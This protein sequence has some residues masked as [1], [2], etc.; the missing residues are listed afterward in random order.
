MLDSAITDQL[1]SL[2]A[3]LE[4]SLTLRLRPSEHPR[5]QELRD[6]LA[7]VAGTSSAITV[8]EEGEP[9]PT[10]RFDILRGDEETGITFRAI[11]GG[12]ELSSLVLALLNA[13][14]KGKLPDEGLRARIARL[15]GPIRLRTYVSLSC[16][17]CPDVVQYLDQLALLHDDFQH[18]IV[19]GALVEE[20]VAQLGIQAVP[21]VFDVAGA[22][23]PR[24]LRVGKADLPTLLAALEEQYGTS[25]ETAAPVTVKDYD[26]AVIGGGPAGAAAAIYS[27][28]KGLSTVVIA[29]QLGGQVRDTAGIE[30]LI[31]VSYT[32]GI[33][34]AADLRAHI[35]HNEIDLLE[36]RRVEEVAGGAEKT[37]R[38]QGGEVVRTRFLIVATGA[39]WRELGVPGEREYLG[40][41]VAFCPHCDGPFYKGRP[42]AVVGGGNSGIEAAIDLAGICSHVTVLEFAEQLNADEVLIKRLEQLP[43]V[44]VVTGARATEILGDGAKVTG[45]AW[46]DRKTE[47]QKQRELEGVFV[48]I[49]LVPNS[50]LV[51]ELVAV[52]RAGEIEVDS[53]CRTSAAGIYAAGDVTNVPW[54][55]IVIAMGEGAKAALAAFED[56]IRLAEP[57]AG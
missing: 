23:D 53:K 43:N 18:E 29:E 54:K 10:P 38:L 40:R 8:A 57:A 1:K 27:A 34:L 22:G 20:E 33:K 31:S 13:D 9:S 51:R 37:I 36:H 46:Q 56:R 7:E 12:H 11:P 6:L 4:S 32:E 49:G 28:R 30:N 3:E 47:Q 2:F 17:N 50:A 25:R 26:V 21:S 55:Q 39:R 19:D 44:D 48:Q 52:N 35:E 16:T 14:G 24:L 45:I 41:G 42:V 15:A 5:Q